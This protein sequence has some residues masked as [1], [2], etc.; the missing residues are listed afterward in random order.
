[1][2]GRHVEVGSRMT[3]VKNSQKNRWEWGTAPVKGTSLGVDDLIVKPWNTLPGIDGLI[4]KRWRTLPGIDGLIVK[5]WR[6][7]AG[8]DGLIV[9]RWR[10]LRS[11]D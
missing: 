8:I 1:M 2:I 10:T 7:W 6:T 4:V 9:K 3:V 11:R 5:R